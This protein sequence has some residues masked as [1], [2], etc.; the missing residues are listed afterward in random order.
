MIIRTIKGSIEK[1]IREH[2]ESPILLAGAKG[3]GKST[4]AREIGKSFHQLIVVDLETSNDRKIFDNKGSFEE[5]MQAIFF[6]RNKSLLDHKTLVFLRE[7]Q[8]C[9]GAVTWFREAYATSQPYTIVASTSYISPEIE[10]AH[11][12][13]VVFPSV[14]K[15][16]PL[17]FH[18]FLVTTAD[19]AAIDAFEEAP[20]PLYAYEKLLNYFHLYS[21]IGGMPEIVSDYFTNQDMKSLSKIYE[22]IINSFEKSIV[23]HNRSAKTSNR[24]IE[25]LQNS[26]PYAATRIIYHH[27]GNSPHQTREIALA[28]RTLEKH[29]LLQLVYPS[30]STTVQTDIARLKSPRLQMIDTGLVNYFSGIQ[31]PLFQSHDMNAI[32]EGQIAKQVVGQEIAATE[33]Q[34]ELIFW[35]RNKNQSTA[36]IDFV[37][38]FQNMMIPV[39]VKSSEPG[40]LRSLHQYVDEAPH[41]YAVRLSA[42]KLSIRQAQTIKGKKYYLLNLPYFLASKIMV[43]LQGFIRLAT[44]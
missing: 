23:F 42:E 36:E 28:F 24:I 8:Y 29:M 11:K 2:P 19:Q 10:S 4:L 9:P 22:M 16:P 15:I 40:R 33:R 27:F 13:A 21:L 14:F 20:V 30:T 38:P 37:I 35:T 1:Y 18:E 32:F 7:I 34:P 3:T 5:I 26:F 6:I 41:P 25:I 31:K 12:L 39:T 43:H 44:S 17:T